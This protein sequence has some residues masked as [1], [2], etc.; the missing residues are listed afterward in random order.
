VSSSSSSYETSDD[1]IHLAQCE[2]ISV[3]VRQDT[4]GVSYSKEDGEDGWTPVVKRR[5]KKLV[6]NVDRH[7]GSD[8]ESEVDLSL[9]RETRFQVRDNIP[10]IYVRNGST[11]RNVSWTP[12][13][14]SHISQRTR[15]RLKLT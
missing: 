5:R 14:P 7:T 6:S 8:S 11:N 10:G 1:D 9:S 15:S 12:I 4:V 2:N 13:K 3:Q